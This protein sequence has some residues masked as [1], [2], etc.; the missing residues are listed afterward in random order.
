M[1]GMTWHMVSAR[2]ATPADLPHPAMVAEDR[3][4]ITAADLPAFG[5]ADLRVCRA[6]VPALTAADL[7]PRPGLETARAPPMGMGAVTDTAAATAPAAVPSRV[8]RTGTEGATGTVTDWLGPE[9]GA[10]PATDTEP[11]RPRPRVT[12]TVA[13]AAARIE[14]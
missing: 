4:A 7:L 5:A 10:V 2:T 9:M 11:V 3:P 6:V 12:D 1:P 8:P 13:T 14:E